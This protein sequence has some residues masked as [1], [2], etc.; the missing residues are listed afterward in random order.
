MRLRSKWPKR[1]GELGGL[2]VTLVAIALLEWLLVTPPVGAQDAVGGA[3]LDAPSDGPSS[4][5][6]PGSDAEESAV[7]AHSGTPVHVT[8]ELLSDRVRAHAV[9]ALDATDPP[10]CRVPCALDLTPGRWQLHFS[11]GIDTN[12]DVGVT[13]LLVQARPMDGTELGIGISAVV[14]GLVALAAVGILAVEG[15]GWSFDGTGTLDYGPLVLG[16]G[17]M[18]VAIGIG[19]SVDSGAS[20]EVTALPGLHRPT[21]D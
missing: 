12:L 1:S 9:D 7:E 16:V 18:T 19:L 5:R 15:M 10:R 8:S 3:G 20:V 17:A 13:T 6:A 2:P 11:S 4:E 21:E 14:I